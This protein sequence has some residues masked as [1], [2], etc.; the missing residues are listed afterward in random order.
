MNKLDEMK[1]DLAEAILLRR[2]ENEICT[3][4]VRPTEPDAFCGGN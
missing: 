4:A 3:Q 1:H 2:A